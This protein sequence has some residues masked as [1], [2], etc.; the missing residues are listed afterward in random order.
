MFYVN[1]FRVGVDPD[2]EDFEDETSFQRV[3]S[4]VRFF[5]AITTAGRAN[6][7]RIAYT[8]ESEIFIFSFYAYISPVLA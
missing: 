2:D 7:V 4:S 8:T 5:L 3:C 1:L 6:N